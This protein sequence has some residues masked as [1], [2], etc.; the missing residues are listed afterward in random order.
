MLT[1]RYK[2]IRDNTSREGFV[3]D[4]RPST[5]ALRALSIW[6]DGAAGRSYNRHIDE[7]DVPVAD[8]RSSET[9]HTAGPDL[10]GSCRRFEVDRSH[11][12]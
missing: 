7:D 8:F 10:D 12:G 9:D 11:V 3:S 5:D 2:F 1:A 6:S 4:N